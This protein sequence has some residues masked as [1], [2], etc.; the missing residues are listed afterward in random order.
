MQILTLLHPADL[1]R[2]RRAILPSRRDW[3]KVPEILAGIL[4]A[5]VRSS[6][7]RHPQ[8]TPLSLALPSMPV[9]Q[10]RAK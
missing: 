8:F 10:R 5:G 1:F 2:D 9:L 7:P 4:E 3:A 6:S